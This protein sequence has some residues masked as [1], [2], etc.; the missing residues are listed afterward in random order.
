MQR[1]NFLPHKFLRID[2]ELADCC[3]GS[4]QRFLQDRKQKCV[5]PQR[6]THNQFESSDNDFIAI[7]DAPD[8]ETSFRAAVEADSMTGTQGELFLVQVVTLW[9]DF[10][11]RT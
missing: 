1:K 8:V 11:L 5:L 9:R 10:R 3:H 6:F 7:E 4:G 2:F